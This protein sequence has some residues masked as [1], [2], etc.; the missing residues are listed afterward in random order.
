MSHA[1]VR[2]PASRLSLDEYGPAGELRFSRSQLAVVARMQ[3]LRAGFGLNYAAVAL[4]T[5]LLDRIAVL[6]A[7]LRGSRWPGR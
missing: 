6:E 1:I 2:V 3:R 4:V 7:A 5:D